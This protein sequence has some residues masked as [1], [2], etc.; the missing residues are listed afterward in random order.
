M[1]CTGPF[2]KFVVHDMPTIKKN[3]SS[4]PGLSNG[5]WLTSL[6]QLEEQ[7]KKMAGAFPI[8]PPL[9]MVGIRQ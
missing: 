3:A 6:G 2:I 1:Y 4:V 5:K 9:I 7:L 8:T